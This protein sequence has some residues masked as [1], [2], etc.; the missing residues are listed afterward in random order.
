[1][2]TQAS[3]PDINVGNDLVDKLEKERLWILEQAE[4]LAGDRGY[5][6]TK[7]IE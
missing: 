2:V 3:E 4:T 7:L 6:D 1:M 5:D